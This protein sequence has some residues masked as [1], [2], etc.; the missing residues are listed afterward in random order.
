LKLDASAGMS[1][2]APAHA[3][4]ILRGEQAIRERLKYEDL[5]KAD[6]EKSL[7]EYWT[8]EYDFI[9][10]KKVD[11]AYD[12]ATGEERFTMDG[13]AKM[14]WKGGGG[15]FG[16]R[17]ETDGGV[18]GWKADISRDPGPDQDAPFSVYYPDYTLNTE[19]IVLPNHGAGFTVEGEDVDKT[20]AQHAFKRVSKIENGVFTMEA[21]TRALA[22][23]FPAADAPAAKKDLA[24]LRSV[25]VYVRAPPRYKMTDQELAQI[26]AVPT[27]A[28]DFFEIAFQYGLRDDYPHA[29]ANYDRAIELKPDWALAYANRGNDHLDLDEVDKA[30]ADMDKALALD[31]NQAVALR[32]RGRLLAKAGKPKEAI[33]FFTRAQAAEP[34]NTYGLE[35]RA[36]AYLDDHDPDKALAD[37]RE[38]LRLDPR[39]LDIHDR[40]IDILTS[41]RDS[42]GLRAEADALA[43]LKIDSAAHFARAY[44]FIYEGKKE[45]ARAELTT[46]L[47][48]TPNAN[49]YVT[50][51]QLREKSERDDAFKDIDAALKLKPDFQPAYFARAGLYLQANKP[52][53][54]IKDID[55]LLQRVPDSVQLG[56]MRA[57]ALVKEHQYE[58][59]I[60]SIDALLTKTP[61]N[62]VLLNNR[63]WYRALSGE[64][65]DVALAACDASLEIEQSSF[66]TWDSRGMVELKLGNLDD[67]ITD[68]DTAL[69]LHPK[70]PGSLF[71]RGIAKLRKGATA[72]G[73]ADL[74]AARALDPEVEAEYADYGVKP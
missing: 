8:K 21:S 31:P 46:A 37:Y 73:Q 48:A 24:D 16:E 72:D 22:P 69:K 74:A 59:A 2:P 29:I 18:L 65:L 64:K 57:L 20:A 7:R 6:S 11:H 14:E 33:E 53:M 50:R 54:A 4:L 5:T 70:M 15:N 38:L 49:L 39:R 1:L 10:V 58:Q 68:Y 34:N 44:A 45:E 27:T 71:A 3:E 63:C 26:S 60:A 43:G 56:E 40:V 35:H 9:D 30:T 36:L 42:A 32:G 66:A 67:A 28:S 51:A 13:E 47:A 19:T 12:E 61:D 41:R 25:T 17:Y 52:D 62:P 23:E 55:W